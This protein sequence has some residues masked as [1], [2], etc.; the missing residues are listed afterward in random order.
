MATAVGF[1]RGFFVPVCATANC[2]VPCL[3][4]M[5]AWRQLCVS[6]HLLPLQRRPRRLRVRWWLA[7]PRDASPLRCETNARYPPWHECLV[8]T[9]PVFVS[10]PP[11]SRRGVSASNG[12]PPGWLLGTARLGRRHLPEIKITR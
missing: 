12:V 4:I 6:N 9:I 7:P 5:V 3:Q 11:S 8:D 1:A 10:P 2:K